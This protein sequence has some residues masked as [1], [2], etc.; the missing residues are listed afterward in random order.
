MKPYLSILALA[1][2]LAAPVQSHAVDLTAYPY[3]YLSHVALG[4]GLSYW[5]TSETQRPE[6]G[7]L[8][9]TVAGALKEST[10]KNFDAGD[11]A[12]WVVGGVVGAAIGE[13]LVITPAGIVWQRRW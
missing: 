3:D 1:A 6:L 9:A 12:S 2:A 13:H 11:L 7:I 5:V 8:A 10:D 4:G